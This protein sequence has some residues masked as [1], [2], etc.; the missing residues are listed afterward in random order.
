M[1]FEEESYLPYRAT[2]LRGERLLVLAPHPDD[3]VIGWGGLVALHAA[4]QRLVRVIIATDGAAGGAGDPRDVA[5]IREQE[6]AAALGALGIPAPEFLR[7]PDRA[8]EQQGAILQEALR[9][10]LIEIR[11]DLILLP[12]PLD[13][14]PDHRALNRAFRELVAASPDL[15]LELPGAR[16]GFYETSQPF[17]PNLL[18]D[19]TPVAERKFEAIAA[20]RSQ[21]AIRDYSWHSRGLAQYRALTLPT[22]VRFAEAYFV[23]SLQELATRSWQEILDSLSNSLPPVRSEEIVPITVIIRTRNRHAFLREAVESVR[24]NSYPAD[25][26]VVN[27]AGA[28]PREILGQHESTRLIDLDQP[29]GRS[30][31]MN[32]GVRA[33]TTALIAFLDDDD[34]YY[35]EH[36][37]TLARASISIDARAWYT[38]A[39]SVFLEPGGDGRWEERD[40]MRIFAEDFDRE[41]L[42][43]DNYIPLLTLLVRRE[44]FLDSGGFSPDLDL[45]EDWDFLL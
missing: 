33:A 11:P 15:L 6:S 25:I 17:R 12:S 32:L 37:E 34:L 41:L 42:L 22:E 43:F 44:D 16:A 9:T 27:D 1:Q 8:L 31:A 26:T 20:H 24:R 7:L 5:R 13:L 18:V 39:V 19:I 21:Q 3:E 35:P 36:L 10:R 14:H 38:D 28:S 4:D 40:R 45:F 29:A 30:E 23:V 2:E